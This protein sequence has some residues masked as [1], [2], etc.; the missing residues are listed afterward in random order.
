MSNYSAKFVPHDYHLQVTRY[1]NRFAR[2]SFLKT[3]SPDILTKTHPHRHVICPGRWRATRFTYQWTSNTPC[4]QELYIQESS[5]RGLRDDKIHIHTR[6]Y[7][8]WLTCLSLL[9]GDMICTQQTKA[10]QRYDVTQ[11]CSGSAR[12]KTR[13]YSCHFQEHSSSTTPSKCRVKVCYSFTTKSG[14]RRECIK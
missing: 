12:S 3:N 9:S 1:A 13:C 8:L 14:V 2:A 11:R 7:V 10:H 6:G 5:A 4:T